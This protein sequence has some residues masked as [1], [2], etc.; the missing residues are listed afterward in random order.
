MMHFVNFIMCFIEF[1]MLLVVKYAIT[2]FS[3]GKVTAN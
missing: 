1:K 3:K 2:F